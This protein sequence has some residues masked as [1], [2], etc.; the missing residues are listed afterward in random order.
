MTP[1]PTLAF[2]EISP[3]DHLRWL[4][5]V[6]EILDVGDDLSEVD[7]RHLL[8]NRLSKPTLYSIED[9]FVLHE[10]LVTR[11]ASEHPED[12]YLLQPEPSARSDGGRGYTDFG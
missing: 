4:A 2:G 10:R 7:G 5:S 1:P 6:Y 11:W 8:L 12:F 9:P 3:G